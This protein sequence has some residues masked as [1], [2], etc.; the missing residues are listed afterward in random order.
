[1][2][3]LKIRIDSST[4]TKVMK[5]ILL[6]QVHPKALWNKKWINYNSYV[7]K[8]FLII[9]TRFSSNREK[10]V[11]LLIILNNQSINF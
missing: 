10:I 1:M 7:K 2:L 5:F 4:W 8:N 6:R 3:W 11:S 9:Q